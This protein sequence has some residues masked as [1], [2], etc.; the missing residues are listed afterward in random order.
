MAAMCLAEAESSHTKGQGAISSEGGEPTARDNQ[1]RRKHVEKHYQGQDVMESGCSRE[2]RGGVPKADLTLAHSLALGAAEVI[3]V[4]L[5]FTL[6]THF[7]NSHIPDS[8]TV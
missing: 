4:H 3:I 8:G 5:S 1:P 7:D 2:H 6:D